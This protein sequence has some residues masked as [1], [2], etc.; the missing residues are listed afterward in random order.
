MFE[1]GN[2]VLSRDAGRSQEILQNL[3][4]TEEPLMIVNVLFRQFLQLW[5]I[6]SHRFSGRATDE[7]ARS[8][9]LVWAWQVENIRKYVKNFPDSAYFERCFEYFLQTDIGIKSQPTDPAVE[10][11]RLVAQLTTR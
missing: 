3:L 11:T 2:A 8:L 10:V 9:G 4:V 6:R 5:R 7:D 1:L